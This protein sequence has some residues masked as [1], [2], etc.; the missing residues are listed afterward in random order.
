MITWCFAIFRMINLI[1]IGILIFYKR[2]D[3]SPIASLDSA[4]VIFTSSRI[5]YV[6]FV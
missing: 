2:K 1:L 3:P 6:P 5:C 4:F